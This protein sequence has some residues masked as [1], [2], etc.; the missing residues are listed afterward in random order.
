MTVHEHFTYQHKLWTYPKPY[1]EIINEM[2][3]D[4]Q[5]RV[6]EWIKQLKLGS[7]LALLD[8]VLWIP[9]NPS[10]IEVHH[11]MSQVWKL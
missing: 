9:C 5:G 3:S 2:A 1:K 7:D 6:E 10:L 8:G 4:G 11:H